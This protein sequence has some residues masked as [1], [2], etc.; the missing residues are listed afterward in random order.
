MSRNSIY[1]LVI[2]PIIICLYE[3]TICANAGIVTMGESSVLSGDDSGNGNLLLAQS[4][5]LTQPGT[6]ESLSFYV[7]TPAGS[8]VLAIYDQDDTSGGPGQLLA[9]T[10]PFTPGQ[11]N[12]WYTQ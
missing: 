8:L 2:A 5:L 12:Q 4:S 11:S 1:R 3:F 7:G 10:R 9:S 6:V